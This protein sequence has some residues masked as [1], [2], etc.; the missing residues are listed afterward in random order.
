M[1]VSRLAI[2]LAWAVI[3]LAA[4]QSGRAWGAAGHRIIGRLAIEALPNDL[5]AFLR[6][7]EAAESVGELAR[8]PDRLRFAGSIHDTDRDPGH[9]LD[10]DDAGKVLGGPSL[11]DLP[12]TRSAFKSALNAAGTDQ[13]RSGY[14]PYAIIDAEEQLAKDF[15]YWRAETAAAQSVANKS[16]SVW[17]AKDVQLR[18]GLILRDLGVLAHYVGDGS[19]PL[20]VSVD[21]NGWG[22]FPN[23]EGFT[24]NRI[25]AYFEGEFVHDYVPKALVQADMASYVDCHCSYEKH[26]CAFLMATN[27]EVAALYRLDKKGGFLNGDERGRA[28]AARRLAACADQ[29]RDDITDAWRA[30]LEGAVGYPPLRISD[31]LAGKI[32]P[33]DALYGLD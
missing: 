17:L 16:H 28:F 21:F 6:T 2:S 11:A 4:P 31:I 9:F 33:Y 22:D 30:S 24:K 13:W 14:L 7:H 10:V 32:D 5:P 1:R 19:Q 25:H 27:A 20:H 18:E 26:A 29:L 15:A 3:G 23:P 8:E 12:S